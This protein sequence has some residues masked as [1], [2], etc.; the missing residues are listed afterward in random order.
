MLKAFILLGMATFLSGTTYAQSNSDAAAQDALPPLD[1]QV[2]EENASLQALKQVQNYMTEVKSLKGSFLQ[3]A[4]GGN[5]SRGTL[6]MARPGKIR[7]DFSDDIPFLVVADGK[8][9]N[10]VDYE[11]GQVQKWPVKDT[12]LLAVIGEGF[13]LASVNAHI[14]VAPEGRK[15]MVSLSANDPDRP[16]MGQIMVFFE[17][18]DLDN[19]GLTLRGWRVLDAQGQ[20]TTVEVYDQET[21]I[22]LLD[23]LWTFEDPRG[24][25]KR[26]R[27]RR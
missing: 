26:R 20:V 3:I 6:Y 10:F 5:L 4:P 12:P 11:I 18:H 21:N 8:T 7:F 2:I 1:E 16:E 25:A 15:N 19:G 22:A 24:I 17:K 13:D 27:T 23:S 14:E 9:I